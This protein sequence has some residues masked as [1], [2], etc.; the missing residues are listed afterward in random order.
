MAP[1]PPLGMLH[2]T[3]TQVRRGKIHAHTGFHSKPICLQQGQRSWP[4]QEC[5]KTAVFWQ[6]FLPVAVPPNKDR[7]ST[8]CLSNYF[9]GDLRT[10]TTNVGRTPSLLNVLF[11]PLVISFCGTFDDSMPTYW[12]IASTPSVFILCLLRF[13]SR[14]QAT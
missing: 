9:N 11:A 14:L 4:V 10:S 3:L 7:P 5:C 8:S 2:A 12:S 1:P 6:E 13:P